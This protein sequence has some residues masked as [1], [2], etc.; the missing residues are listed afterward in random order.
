M[1]GKARIGKR[2]LFCERGS[3]EEKGWGDLSKNRQISDA[4]WGEQE[5]R[6]LLRAKNGSGSSK[7]RPK[8]DAKWGRVRKKSTSQGKKR[9]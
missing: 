9:V 6:A 1:R 8:L 3:A 4:K 5:K 2:V 7:N